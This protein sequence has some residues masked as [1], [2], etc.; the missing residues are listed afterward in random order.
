MLRH[1]YRASLA[2]ALPFLLIGPPAGAALIDIVVVGTWES[3]NNAI[4][5]PFGLVIGDKFVMKAT[6]DDATFFNGSEGVTAD[7]DPGINP[8]T[9]LDFIMPHNGPSPNPVTFDESDHVSIGFAPN[10][11][12]E[13]DGPNA[14]TPGNFRNF[15]FHF[16]NVFNGDSMEYDQFMGDIQEETSIFNISQG[17]NK[18]ATGDGAAHLEVVV[19]DITANAG[20]P[21][22]FNA[23]NLS[24]NLSGTSGGGSGFTKIF[25]WTG[26]GGALT[27]SPGT[28]IAL[29]LAESGLTSTTDTDSVDLTATEMFTDF[30]SA[31][32]SATVSYL[33][34]SPMVLSAS[35]TTE[36]D[37]SITFAASFDDDDLIANALVADFEQLLLE[38]LFEDSVFLTGEDNLDVATLKGIFGPAGSYDVDARVTDL[39]GAS[40]TQ[41]FSITFV[42]EPGA[43]VLTSLGLIG[44]ASVRRRLAI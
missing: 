36:V 2:S 5:N 13:F 22:V 23:A 38:F 11:Q 7:V 14:G 39:A 31:P 4:I 26:P 44:L 12:I 16:E 33:N 30:A 20:G 18:A 19:N 9:S 8:G 27:N 25:D 24:V 35:G 34:T 42:P 41:T 10:A 21:Y 29:G 6:Y 1:L 3:V 17:G 40:D 37:N 15:E 43:F 28:P 32:D